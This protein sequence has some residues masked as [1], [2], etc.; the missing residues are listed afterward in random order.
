M[1]GCEHLDACGL[2]CRACALACG[3][4]VFAKDPFACFY[5]KEG[6]AGRIVECIDGCREDTSCRAADGPG[7][8]RNADAANSSY[9]KR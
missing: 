8:R 5:W 7:E 9:H 6:Y 1:P 3:E 4:G 2:G